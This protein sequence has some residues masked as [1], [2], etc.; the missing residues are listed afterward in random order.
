[1]TIKVMRD[2]LIT[3]VTSWSRISIIYIGLSSYCIRKRIYYLKSVT[4]RAT[5][6]L[7]LS[8]GYVHKHRGAPPTTMDINIYLYYIIIIN[9]GLSIAFVFMWP[10]LQYKQWKRYLSGRCALSL[11]FNRQYN[12]ENCVITR[13]EQNFSSFNFYHNVLMLRG[14]AM[15]L[16]RISIT[17]RWYDVTRV[18]VYQHL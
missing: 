6:V 18:L 1:M 14:W 10:I 2:H 5:W 13:T 15:W 7:C 8:Q 3:Y 12:S 17:P 16:R 11:Y 4:Y 9:D